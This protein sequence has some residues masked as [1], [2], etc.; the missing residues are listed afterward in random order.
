LTGMISGT[1]TA[2]GSFNFM[3]QVS[4]SGGLTATREFAMQ[5]QLL[6]AEP[7]PLSEPAGLA[8]LMA[9]LAAAGIVALRRAGA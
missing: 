6:Q 1:P 9:M 5:I 8:M 7:I 3:L 4:D 2:T